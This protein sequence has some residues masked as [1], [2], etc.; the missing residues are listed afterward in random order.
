MDTIGMQ[1]ERFENNPMV[2]PDMVAH[3]AELPDEVKDLETDSITTDLS[4]L[5]GN[6]NGPSLI[7]VPPWVEEPLGNYYLYFANHQGRFIYLAYADSLS[8]PWELH[9][10]GTLHIDETPFCHHIAS[11][12]VHVLPEQERIRMYYHGATDYDSYMELTNRDGQASSVAHSKN[13][14]EFDSSTTTFGTPYLRRFSVGE[15]E[16]FLS[17]QGLL[18]RASDGVSAFELGPQLLGEGLRHPGVN[19]VGDTLHVYYSRRDNPPES[20]FHGIVDVSRDWHDWTLEN[21]EMVLSPE[22]EYE[23]ADLPVTESEVGFARSR[24]RQVR[25]PYVYTEDGHTYLLYAVAGERG[26]AIA[27]IVP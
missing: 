7:E 19:V 20:I 21:S 18:Y 13:G 16:Y 6:I 24:L 9:A 17:G 2:T 8:G 1:I 12:D 3:T 23:G 5:E 14:I 10:P 27:E 15:W 26:I 4:G 25:D 11:P 22:R